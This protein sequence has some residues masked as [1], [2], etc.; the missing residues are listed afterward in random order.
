[1]DFQAFPKIER[2][3]N[4]KMSITQ[5]I[6]GTN[7]QIVITEVGPNTDSVID[8]GLVESKGKWYQVKAGSRTRWIKVGDDNYGFAAFV[9]A[10]K[11]SI[12]DCLGAGQ[13]FGEWAGP[14][15]NSGEGLIEKT[16]FLFDYWKFPADRPLPPQIKVVPLLYEGKNDLD[17]IENAMNDLK[18]NGSKIVPGFMRPEGVVVTLNG[19][20]YKKVFAAEETQWKKPDEAYRAAKEKADQ[21]P[22][23]SHLCQPIRLEKLLSRDE[24]FLVGYPTTLKLIADEYVKDL[25]IEGQ[26]VDVDK[27][28]LNKFVFPFIR[29]SIKV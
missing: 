26:L 28:Y 23:L 4:L 21:G 20:R 9:E 11:Q 16:L 17:A 10:N 5:K 1:M 3:G 18:T 27:K 6:H 13:H 12:V 7:A 8:A 2:I 29:E 24:R 19:T 14:G 22:D 25:E 15:I